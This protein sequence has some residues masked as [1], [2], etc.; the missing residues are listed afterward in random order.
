MATPESKKGG[1]S[2]ILTGHFAAV[3]NMGSVTE[4]GRRGFGMQ[5]GVF[6]TQMLIFRRRGEWIN[7]L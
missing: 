2:R 3:C 7:K 5:P 4:E 1:E 6:A